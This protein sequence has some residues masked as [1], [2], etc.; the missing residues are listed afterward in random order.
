MEAALS[1]LTAALQQARP[2]PSP[3]PMQLRYQA[4]RRGHGR[5]EPTVL[6]HEEVVA[7]AARSQARRWPSIPQAVE[8]SKLG[9]A[10]QGCDLIH[11]DLTV[12]STLRAMPPNPRIGFGQEGGQRLVPGRGPRVRHCLFTRSTPTQGDKNGKRTNGKLMWADSVPVSSRLLESC[13]SAW[14]SDGHTVA[15]KSRFRHRIA[16]TQNMRIDDS[17]SPAVK[18]KIIMIV[19]AAQ[20]VEPTIYNL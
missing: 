20:P 8:R 4:V 19:H 3:P 9:I 11:R 1:V 17:A 13:L 7:R 6:S 18:M 15:V 16:C 14:L 2:R 10:D 5:D 12:E